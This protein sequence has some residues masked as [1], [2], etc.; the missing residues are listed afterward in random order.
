MA[1][2]RF[3]RRTFLNKRGHHA[4]AYV[5]AEGIVEPGFHTDDG[6]L[7]VSAALTVADCSR[8]VTLDFDAHD[9]ASARN[10]LHKARLLKVV[11]DGFVDA[12]ERAVDDAHVSASER[13]SPRR[14]R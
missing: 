5:I 13:S 10:A 9:S 7:E 2:L 11:V 6:K 12:L 3:Y 4:G 14:G 8:I 1:S